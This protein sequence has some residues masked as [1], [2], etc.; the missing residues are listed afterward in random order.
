MG[1]VRVTVKLSNAVDA[2]MARRGL[3]LREQVRTVT[4]DA[5]VDTGSVRSC[6]PADLKKKLGLETT[7]QINAQVADGQ[8]KSV[9]QTEA[10]DMEILD[11]LTPEARLVLGD[12][13][14]IGQTALE[15][16][17]LIVDCNRQRVITNPDHPN[18]TVIRIR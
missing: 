14:L 13:V 7:R 18:S 11:R 15:G 6:I 5:V 2:G 1:E 3:L 12:E 4:V 10:V 9:E 8:V 17:D 16:T